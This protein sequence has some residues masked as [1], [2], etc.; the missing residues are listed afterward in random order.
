M[1]ES[2]SKR[3]NSYITFQNIA[4]AIICI[5]VLMFVILLK[6]DSDEYTQAATTVY[7][8]VQAHC[9]PGTRPGPSGVTNGESSG[10]GIDYNIRT[11]LNYDPTIAHP[12][13]MV[14]APANANESRTEKITGL[15]YEATAAGFIVAYADHLGLSSTTTVQLGTIPGLIAKKWCVDEKRIFLTGHSDGG[16]VA[17]ALAFMA[18]KS[19]LAAIAPSAAGIAYNDLYDRKCPAPLSVMV[20]HSKNDHLFPG[21]GEESSGWWAACNKCSP[22]PE[23]AENGCI[24][25]PECAKGVKTWFCEGD[26]LHKHWPQMNRTIIAVFEFRGG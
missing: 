21:Y 18:G 11:P 3:L 6:E 25:Y 24:S 15:T 22:I 8:S 14:Y 10:D 26:K 5:P 17:M 4:I 13:L 2:F 12:L 19:N 7:S 1:L 23:K 16:S 9:S 20:M